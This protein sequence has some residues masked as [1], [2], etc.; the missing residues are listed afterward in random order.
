MGDAASTFL[1][2][3]HGTFMLEDLNNP[4]ALRD[5]YCCSKHLLEKRQSQGATCTQCLCRLTTAV[6]DSNTDT[7]KNMQQLNTSFVNW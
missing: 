4:F 6:K 3:D 5:V 7:Y 1:R 2:P